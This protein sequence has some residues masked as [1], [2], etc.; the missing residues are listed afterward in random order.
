MEEGGS[1]VQREVKEER[2]ART[3]MEEEEKKVRGS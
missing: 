2:V 1:S 3:D